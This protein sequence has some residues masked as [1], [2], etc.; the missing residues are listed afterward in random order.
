MATQIYTA[1]GQFAGQIRGDTYH[2]NRRRS[3]HQLRQPPAWA[4]DATILGEL[5]AAGVKRIE[6]REVEGG[7]TYTTT[8][9]TFFKHGIALDRG[10]GRQV[11][12]PLA[13]WRVDGRRSLAEQ[14]TEHE[15]AKQ[16]QMSLFEVSG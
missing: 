6:V 9:E 1:A 7:Q 2:T 15:A 4:I 11:A 3:V 8:L 16:S 10:H 13:Y 14:Q 5:R 12:L